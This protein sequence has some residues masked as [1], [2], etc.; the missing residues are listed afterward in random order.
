MLKV[1]TDIIHH[2]V[3]VTAQ[4]IHNFT[5]TTLHTKKTASSVFIGKLCTGPTQRQKVIEIVILYHEIAGDLLIIRSYP[6][7]K[8][9]IDYKK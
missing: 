7:L 4:N 6:Q 2:S 1:I 8:S 5:S 9:G 3:Q